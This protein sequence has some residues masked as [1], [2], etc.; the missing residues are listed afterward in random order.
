MESKIR[1]SGIDIIGKTS[2]GTHFCLFYQT[3]EDLI[4]ILVPYF[5]AGLENNEYC[6]WVTSEP[7]NEKEAER[8][9]RGAMPN[10]DEYFKKKQI[11]IVHYTEWYLRDG[12]F[13]LDRVLN[14]WVEKI[15]NAIENGFEGLRVTGNTA[16]LE[17]KDWKDF[18]DY[19]E[20]INNV[21]GNFQMMA[22]CTYSLE[23]CGSFELLDVIQNH[24]FALIRRE[25]KWESFKSMEQIAL[26]RKLKETEL[27]YRTTFEQSP[28]GIIIL[29]LETTRAVE[30]NI[31][32]CDILGYSREEF[33]ELKVADYDVIEDPSDA[34]AHVQKVLQQGRDDFE[35]KL[36]TKNGDIKDIHVIAKVIELSGKK[37]FQ[38]IWRDITERKKTERK[39]KESEEKFKALFENTNDAI[40][41]HD[42]GSQ[43]IEVNQTACEKLGYTRKKLLK[44]APKDII[45]PG[46]K[47]DLQANIKALQE[48]GELMI[49]AEHI[50]KDGIIIPVEI[51]SR[52]FN[53]GGKQTIISVVRDI[54]ERKVVEQEL[55]E[56]EEKWRALSENSPA[57]IMLC[58]REHKILFI[59][60][61]V[62]DLSKE[63]VIGIP[64]YNYIPQKDRQLAIDYR[65]SVWETGEPITYTTKYI[66]KKGDTRYFDV[67]HSPVFKNGKITALVSQHIDITERKKAERNLKESEEKYSTLAKL[68]PVGIFHTDQKGDC[69]YVNECWSQISGLTLDEAL[70]AGWINGLHRNDKKRVSAEWYNAAENNIPFESEY[71]FKRLD[72]KITWVYGQAI[73]VKNDLGK[74]TGYIGTITDISERIQA[75]Q[76]LKES[77]ER[78][79]TII[80]FLGDPLHVIDKNYKI[81]LVNET[82]KK[83]VK[84]LNLDTELIGKTP[85]EAWPFLP[86][87]TMEHYHSIFNNGNQVVTV[88]SLIINNKEI[89]T[90]TR[91][92]P[93]LK[94]EKVVQIITLIRDITK[95]KKAER[96]LRLSEEN[97]RNLINNLQDVI[98]EIDTEGKV[99]YV[100]PQIT[101]L[102]GYQL[103]EIIGKNYIGYVHPEDISLVING[104]KNALESLFLSGIEFRMKHKEGYYV[105]VSARGKMISVDGEQIILGVISDITERQRAKEELEQAQHNLGE[106]VKELTCLYGL[107]KLIE[108]PGIPFEDILNGVLKLIPPAFQFPDITTSRI[109]YDGREYKFGNFEETKWKLSTKVEIIERILL[110]EVNYLED[111]PFLKEEHDMIRDIGVRLKATLEEKEA[112]NRL[113]ESEEKYRMGFESST[114]GIASAD[115]EGI[116]IDCNNAFLKMLGYSSKEIFKLGFREVTPQRWHEMEDSMMISQLADEKDSGIYE[117][118]YIRKDGTIFPVNVRF[119]IIKDDQGDPVRMWTIVRDI[120]ERK[121]A[122]EKITSLAKFPSENPHPVLRLNRNKI[123]YMNNSARYLLNVEENDEIPDIIRKEVERAFETNF[124]VDVDIELKDKVYS[125]TITPFVEQNYVNLY[126]M[127]ITESKLAELKLIEINKLKS[128]F[129]RR[130]SHELKTPLISI[131]G[132]SDLILALHKDQISSEIISKLNEI[133]RGCERLQNIINNLLETSRL[134][135]PELKPEV[136]KEDL[137]FLIK[138][139]V[140]ELQSLTQARNQTLDLNIQDG[141]YGIFEKEEIHDVISNLLTN[142][143]KYTPPYGKISINTEEKGDFIM[144]SVKDNGIG[145]TE[146][147]EGRIFKQFGKIERYGQGLDLGIDGTGLG[148]YISKKIVE[149]HGG[150]IWMESEGKSKG[151]TFY[152]TIPSIK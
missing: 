135:S 131:K 144:I 48:K 80:N 35:T 85:K 59:N 88:G 79:R 64:A 56:S 151:T 38:S 113:R 118:E 20:E 97:Y 6:M 31:A 103:E 39:L 17:D 133:N 46:F 92:I 29:D 120:T 77:E 51:N 36:R 105:F 61:T 96:E 143:I 16:W 50:T 78:Y 108:S 12:V 28:D 62:P 67:W 140:H 106:R 58:D 72:G 43:F 126:G 130:A 136:Q 127:D 49:E 76:K 37:Y 122:E 15:E 74:I 34:R 100:S 99:T 142:A 83:W 152:F 119:W 53:F 111:K 110:I 24:Q 141:Q 40:F 101:S 123:I 45:P 52:V 104:I 132:Y 81:I 95:S 3:K 116:F 7:L 90:E 21:I 66:T 125:F 10:F 69:L 54:T 65:D 4:D 147:Q 75:E 30:F 146:E 13:D 73:A 42:R 44:L 145:F 86:D 138:F 107:S 117:K 71:R 129:L 33:A 134:E 25:G 14:G 109:T 91:K 112:Q 32:I 102:L 94:K 70:G 26:E 1:N 149:S 87:W 9:I 98:A 150:E 137:S 57:H 139:C 124:I 68:S 121:K 11:E 5:K 27:R 19:E 148:L 22:I 82:L 47:I 93:I 60:R 115:M 84:N 18:R 41:I 128:E 89:T 63:E 2:W 8:A 23:K 55:K 114:D